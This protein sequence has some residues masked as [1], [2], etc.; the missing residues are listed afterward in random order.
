MRK[1]LGIFATGRLGGLVMEKCLHR[2][3]PVDLVVRDPAHP[4]AK[5]LQQF[6]AR[7]FPFESL[8]PGSPP[9]WFE[10]GCRAY[11]GG[12]FQRH[13]AALDFLAA[14]QSRLDRIVFV[15]SAN[16]KAG[17]YASYRDFED[18]EDR[19]LEQ[20][21]LGIIIKPTLVFGLED[22]RNFS[23]MARW[24]RRF[25]VFP[26]IGSGNA[27]YQPVHYEDLA[28]ATAGALE[29]D[30]L[31]SR[32][33]FV[34]GRDSLPYREIVRFLRD[35]LR[36]RCLIL[37]LPQTLLR[38]ASATVGRIIKLPLSGEQIARAHVDRTVDNA[39]ATRD[40]GY[41]PAPT[42]ERL[43]EAIRAYSKSAE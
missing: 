41:Q 6:G 27:I 36:A 11:V 30:S 5:R 3:H 24:M 8:D 4:G 12:P 32:V 21:E 18:Y 7:V 16:A 37:P 17:D 19:I 29:A 31:K 23:R 43:E 1:I 38:A 13:A 39:P 40:F 33:Y 42:L 25:P 20:I 10:D 2:G 9:D 34:G 35:G 26:Q 14:Q 28:E 22:D 15:S